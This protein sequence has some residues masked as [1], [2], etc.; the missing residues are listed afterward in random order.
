MKRINILTLA[1]FLV[2][3]AAVWAQ[4]SDLVPVVAKPV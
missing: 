4:S 2:P 1:S 3:L